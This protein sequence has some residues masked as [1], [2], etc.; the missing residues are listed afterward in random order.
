V[1]EVWNEFETD[2]LNHLIEI[3]DNPMVRLLQQGCHNPGDN[4]D[5]W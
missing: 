2:L 5:T 1:I 4:I 3:M